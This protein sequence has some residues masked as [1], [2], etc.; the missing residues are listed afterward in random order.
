MTITDILSSPWV[1]DTWQYLA[2]GTRYAPL[3]VNEYIRAM[4]GNRV[5]DIGCGT[6][7]LLDYLPPVEYYGFDMSA[8]YIAACR[9]RHGSKGTFLQRQLTSDT[10]EE[11][12]D[13][14]VVVATGVVH[15]LDDAEARNLFAVSKAALKPGGRLVTL[16]G[17]YES[18][19]SRIAKLL[20]DGDRGK[21]V[22]TESGYREIAEKVFPK[23][24][25]TILHRMFRMPYTVIIMDCTA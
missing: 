22:R 11:Y 9:Q 16:D 14:D 3:F 15:H 5:L 20:L 12:V 4:Q 13:C 18:G 25:C 24:S 7:V 21:Y 8:H 19:Q 17:C 23:V 1:Y 2:R 6:G 10:V